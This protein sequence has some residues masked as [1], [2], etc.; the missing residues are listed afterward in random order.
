MYNLTETEYES[1]H[2]YKD[3]SK[4]YLF[5]SYRNFIIEKALK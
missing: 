2:Y 3:V 4:S 5:F 1:Q